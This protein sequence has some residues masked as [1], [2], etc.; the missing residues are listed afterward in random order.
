[1]VRAR[2]CL[3]AGAVKEAVAACRE[4]LDA[5][6]DLAGD[7]HAL[8]DTIIEAHSG[9]AEARTGRAFVRIRMQEIEAACEDL[10][11]ALRL[12]RES[13]AEVADLAGSIL[14][15]QPS[16][17]RVI[18]L[19]AAALRRCGDL[20]GAMRCLDDALATRDGRNDLDL[21]LF[22]RT[23]AVRDG[24]RETARGLLGRAG[25]IA[26]D[27]DRLLAMLH[28]EALGDLDREQGGDGVEAAIAEGAWFLAAERLRDEVSTRKAW[29]LE[30]A[31]RYAEAAATLQQLMDG[32]A[33]AERFVV[34]HDRFV[35]HGLAGDGETLM[36]EAV[37]HFE[38]T[39]SMAGEPRA[40]HGGDAAEAAE[41]GQA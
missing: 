20:A 17:G 35:S 6:A 5:S 4:A 10:A 16:D 1:M 31:G 37:L 21:I 24:D 19:R 22:R 2:A 11:E 38:K 26:K 15:R 3:S 8:L 33:A 39:G 34:L 29:L 7:A 14:E 41:G 18:R 36:A 40:L 32:D 13:A 9:V 30:K 28:R 23:L 27:R 12:D 25:E